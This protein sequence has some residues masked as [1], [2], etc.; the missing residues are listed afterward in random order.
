[1]IETS[2]KNLEPNR[3]LDFSHA[4]T[5][6]MEIFA[7]PR[8]FSLQSTSKLPATGQAP[9]SSCLVHLA[10]GKTFLSSSSLY[11][12]ELMDERWSS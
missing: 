7:T 8:M 5:Q 1:M 3:D 10:K 11:H 4:R 6:P 12:E 2:E 9:V